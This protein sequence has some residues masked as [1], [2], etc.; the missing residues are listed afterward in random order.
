MKVT[1]DKRQKVDS[2]TAGSSRN[3]AV[4][5]AALLAAITIACLAPFAGKAFHIDDPLFLWTARHIQSSPLDPYGFTI[6]WYGIEQSAVQIVKNPPLASYFIALVA[7]L[8]GWS[9]VALHLAFLVPAVGVTLGTYFLARRFCANPLAAALAGL[10]TPVFLLSATTLMCDVMMLAFWVW[11]MIA[12]I[13]GLESKNGSM[14][15]LGAVLIAASSLTKYFGISLIPLLFLY[16]LASRRRLGL[17]ALYLLIPVVVLGGYQWATHELYGRGL[18]LDAGA[19]AVGARERLGASFLP[20]SLIG[21]AFTGGCMLVTLLYTPLLWPRKVIIPA[22]A[23]TIALILSLPLAKTV[24]VFPLS[25]EGGARWPIAVQLGIFAAG[26]VGVLALATSDVWKRRDAAST[27]LFLWI[28]G[29]FVFAGYF[30]W[31]VNGRSIL[32]MVPAAGILLMRRLEDNGLA[33]QPAGRKYLLWPL[34]PSAIL[35]LLVAWADCGLAN[36]ARI[37]AAEI[38][39]EYGATQTVWFQGHWG[40]QYYME[41]SGGKAV[42]EDFS[43]LEPGDILVAPNNNTNVFEIPYDAFQPLHLLTLPV[44]SWLSTLN[45]ATGAGFFSD[46]CGPLPFV[47]GAAPRE[48]Y[49]I[50]RTVRTYCGPQDAQAQNELGLLLDKHGNLDEAIVHYSEAVRLK[51]GFAQ[52]HYNLGRAFAAQNRLDEA[53]VHFSE[54]LRLRPNYAQAHNDLGTAL[55]VQGKIREAA[56]NFSEAVRIKPNYAEAHFN[57]GVSFSTQGKLDEAVAQYEKVIAIKPAHAGAHT[58]L[59]VAL[60]FKGDYTGAWKEVRLAERYGGS[61]HPDFIRALSE[62]MPEP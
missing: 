1:P 12:W 55:A 34:V 22:L 38:N 43:I 6:N 28:A 51:P 11:A 39:N 18:L 47:F 54:A 49:R 3:E 30:N 44:C 9:E 61:L 41:S 13:R 57:L 36:S 27:L 2:H 15:A 50:Y 45:P 35:A 19:Y 29:T 40:F 59:A 32:P 42:D 53:I 26:G 56:L 5:S 33:F 20:K 16:S 31:S 52:A 23:F 17:W 21:L 24:G 46:E 58:N 37:A 8:V 62:K 4:R 7:L 60:Y 14:L 10:L 48:E 25:N